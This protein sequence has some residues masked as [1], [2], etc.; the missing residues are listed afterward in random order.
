MVEFVIRLKGKH[1]E[2]LNNFI[3][4]GYYV[5]KSEVIRAGLLELA[6]KFKVQEEYEYEPTREE[7]ILVNKGIKKEMEKIKK[8]KMKVYSHEEFLKRHPYLKN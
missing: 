4:K 5:T 6:N 3:N 8:G 1:E 2:L 7:V